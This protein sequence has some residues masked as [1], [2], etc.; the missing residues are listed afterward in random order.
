MR[1]RDTLGEPDLK[2]LGFQLWIHGRQAPEAND[3]WD[4]NWLLVTAHCGTHGA[5][6]WVEGPIIHLPEIA[7][8]LQACEQMM[9]RVAGEAELACLEPELQIQLRMES[10]GHVVMTVEITPD[11]M[12][13]QHEFEF[14]LDESYLP[15]LVARCR[16]ILLAYPIRGKEGE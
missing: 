8:W 9:T 7:R 1:T 6:V 12:H 4:G 14:E 16:R 5:D 10:L 15:G 11:H 2:L 13:Q 3:Y